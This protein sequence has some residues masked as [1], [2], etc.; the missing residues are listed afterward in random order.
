[1]SNDFYSISEQ[2][3]EEFSDTLK[4]IMDDE[5]KAGNVIRET[6]RGWPLNAIVIGL[7]YSF[8][9]QHEGLPQNVVFREVNDPH[10]WK[11]E[12]VDTVTKD[13]LICSF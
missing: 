10:Y 6:W 4:K 1:M 9:T 5:L 2:D 12:Y 8:K 13:M 7:R 3:I 11:A